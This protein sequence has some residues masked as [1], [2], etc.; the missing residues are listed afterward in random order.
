MITLKHLQILAQTQKRK[1]SYLIYVRCEAM[2][3][4]KQNQNKNSIRIQAEE[5]VM[6]LQL[7]KNLSISQAPNVFS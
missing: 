5:V 6:Q 4:F 2:L 7:F 1:G 3:I